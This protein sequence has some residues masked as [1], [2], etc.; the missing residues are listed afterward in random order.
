VLSALDREL[1][2]AARGKGNLSVLFLDLDRFKN[3]NDR[4][5]HLVGSR[6]LLEL[7]QLLQSQI[8]A[9]D[10]IGRYGGDEFTILLVDTDHDRALEVGERIRRAVEGAIFSADRGL[11]LQLT[12]SIGVASYPGNGDTSEQLLDLSDKAMYLGKALGRNMVC[13][14]MELSNPGSS[15]NL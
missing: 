6:V 2:R 14:A 1:S 13:S 3:V 5:G 8:R 12:L 11:E 4:Y 7:G 10:T 9:I 15:Q